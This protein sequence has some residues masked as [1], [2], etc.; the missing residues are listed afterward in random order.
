[1]PA[2]AQLQVSTALVWGWENPMW[3]DL[4][5]AIIGLGLIAALFYRPFRELKGSQIGVFLFGVAL[6]V[7]AISGLTK[8]EGAG[9]KL[10]R[11]AFDADRAKTLA[12]DLHANLALM[13]NRDA[14]QLKQM[15]GRV[16]LLEQSIQSLAKKADPAAVN[17]IAAA[18]VPA[19]ARYVVA[20]KQADKI[21]RWIAVDRGL[22]DIGLGGGPSGAPRI[23]PSTDQISD[24]PIVTTK[25]DDVDTPPC[26][27]SYDPRS[28]A[29]AKGR[30]TSSSAPR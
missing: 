15:D 22:T 3:R 17:Q 25:S 11:A 12:N 5:T 23:D 4:A 27:T 8:F 10:E 9:L 30:D 16:V 6:V 14:N 21:R 18:Q 20:A 13:A 24:T 28:A 7:W 26:C 29:D 19:R 1:M 2:A